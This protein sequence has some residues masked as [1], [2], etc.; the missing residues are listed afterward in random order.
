MQRVRSVGLT[1]AGSLSDVVCLEFHAVCSFSL[2]YS[3]TETALKVFCFARFVL[4]A[5]GVFKCYRE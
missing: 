2:S 1:W 3:S 4:Q 5:V